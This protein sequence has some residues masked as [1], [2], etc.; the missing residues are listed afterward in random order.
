LRILT[1]SSLTTCKLSQLT[2]FKSSGEQAVI[3][4]D[5]DFVCKAHSRNSQIPGA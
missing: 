3:H 4:C 5:T 1:T 2:L